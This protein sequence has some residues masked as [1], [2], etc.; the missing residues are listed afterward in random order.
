MKLLDWMG[1]RGAS[2]ASTPT[3]LVKPGLVVPGMRCRICGLGQVEWI[4]KGSWQLKRKGIPLPHY[5]CYNCQAI[6]HVKPK[7]KRVMKR[8]EPWNCFKFP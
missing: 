4:D 2:E 3:P 5:F 8:S 1:W 6:F 7:R